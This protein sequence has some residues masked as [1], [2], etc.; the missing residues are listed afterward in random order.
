MIISYIM[1]Q[2]IHVT[3]DI[4][5][6][7]M[8]KAQGT[9]GNTEAQLESVQLESVHRESVIPHQVLQKRRIWEKNMPSKG[10]TIKQ[11]LI[12]RPQYGSVVVGLEFRVITVDDPI[13]MASLLSQMG[14]GACQRYGQIMHS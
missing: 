1:W 2:G 12:I 6:K 7:I 14:S 11:P 8:Q 13:A 5:S 3:Q 10:L 9:A 4:T